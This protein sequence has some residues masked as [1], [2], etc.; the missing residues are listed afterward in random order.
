[1]SEA[2]GI[3]LGSCFYRLSSVIWILTA[4]NTRWVSFL[5]GLCLRAGCG[6]G[7]TGVRATSV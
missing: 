5:D 2:G 6:G 1:M 7:E 4:P 3:E